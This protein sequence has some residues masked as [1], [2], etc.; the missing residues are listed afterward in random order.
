MAEKRQIVQ[1]PA[2]QVQKLVELDKIRQDLAGYPISKKVHLLLQE[3]LAEILKSAAEK[4]NWWVWERPSSVHLIYSSAYGCVKPHLKEWDI[5]WPYLYGIFRKNMV[6]W[7]CQMEDM[8]SCGRNIVETHFMKDNYERS[9]KKWDY[10]CDKIHALFNKLEKTDI[11]DLSDK[12]LS[13]L[14]TKFDREYTDWWGCTQVV[15]PV[16][17]GTEAMLK[18]KLAPEQIKKYFSILISPTQKSYLNFEEE[19][20][21]EIIKKIRENKE[22]ESLFKK[23]TEEIMKNLSKFPEIKK[24]LEKHSENYYWLSNNYYETTRLG[25]DYFIQK[26]KEFLDEKI[27][28]DK[29][30]KEAD[31]RFAKTKKDKENIMKELNLDNRTRWIIKIIDDFCYLQDQRK[32]LNLIGNRFLDDFCKEIARRKKIDYD[33]LTFGTP[34]QLKDTI[35]GKI[36]YQELEAQKENCLIMITT[37]KTEVFTGR[38]AIEKEEE[39]LGIKEIQKVHEIEGMTA[40]GGRYVGKVRVLLN[41]KDVNKMQKGEVLVTTMTSP[42]FI[43]AMKKA[44]AIV[45]D[46]GG[47]TSHASVVS[48]ELGIPCVIATKIA[49]KVLE[50]GMEVEVKANHGLVRILK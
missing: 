47:I 30:K 21:F 13:E 38:K 6:K 8:I 32:L 20:I 11:K 16:S 24:M 3:K 4:K 42:D 33:L 12:E 10:R 41:P 22:A 7:I 19:H 2:E 14:Y 25:V 15:E 28:T 35:A 44:G 17:Y 49:T 29:M 5:N 27:D 36:P 1:I 37:D 40:N 46:E 39:L 50:D 48:R 26:I 9:I 23:N 45:T 43:V 18:E 34:Q 31:E